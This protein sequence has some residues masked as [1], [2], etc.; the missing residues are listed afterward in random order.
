MIE[1]ME[2]LQGD[3]G[4]EDQW[5]VGDD[6]HCRRMSQFTFVSATVSALHPPEISYDEILIPMVMVILG[7]AF[8]R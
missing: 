5:S 2:W 6:S 1:C 4:N 7:W 8:V 3:A